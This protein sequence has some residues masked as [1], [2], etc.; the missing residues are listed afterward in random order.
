MIPRGTPPSYFEVAPGRIKLF[1]GVTPKGDF[2]KLFT[3]ERGVTYHLAWDIE[4]NVPPP[5]TILTQ[6]EMTSLIYAD[7]VAL[8][9]IPFKSLLYDESHQT[10]SATVAEITS[11]EYACLVANT[12]RLW[13]EMDDQLQIDGQFEP[14]RQQETRQ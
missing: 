10:K 12:F 7:H 9:A 13:L 8:E 4:I 1:V 6:E 3:N 11:A 2:A 14:K 5:A